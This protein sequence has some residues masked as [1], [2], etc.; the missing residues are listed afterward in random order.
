MMKILIVED[1]ENSR[2]LLEDVLVAGEYEVDSAVNGLEALRKTREAPADLIISDILMPEMDGFDLCRQLK[3]DPQLK[4]IPFIFYT[5][6]YTD[7]RDEKFAMSLGATRFVIKPEDPIRLLEIIKEVFTEQ[8]VGLNDT[9]PY[10]EDDNNEFEVKHSEVLSKKL[11]K[12]IHEIEGQKEQLK[13]IT[14][15]IPALISEIDEFGCYQYSN[16]AHEKW[17]GVSGDQIIGKQIKDVAGAALYE[18]VQP[19]IQKALNGEE[20][21]FEGYVTVANADKRYILA[22]YIPYKNDKMKSYHCFSFINDL[23]PQKQ[24]E[25]EKQKLL[26]QL[27]QSQKQDAIGHLAG[28]IAHDFNNILSIIL[29]YSELMTV[30]EYDN[31]S[32]SIEAYNH[33]IRTAGLRGQD[34]I[35]QIM[36]FSRKSDEQVGF[37]V[38]IK[39]LIKEVIKLVQETF[40]ATVVIDTD[41]A[42]SISSVAIELSQ[43]HQIMVNL[44]VNARDAI[45]LHG[46]ILVTLKQEKVKS[47]V[48]SSCKQPFEGNYVV[49]TISDD[50][51]GIG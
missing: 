37:S 32:G 48:C 35:R 28:G 16:K 43:L 41:L 3:L 26:L 8:Q 12:K 15:A 47:V 36:K 40:P 39:P 33:Q 42:E 5:A 13:F 46:R 45:N 2:I 38:D 22:R 19:Y 29:G 50:G 34:L 9:K 7:E 17:F 21:V 20:A 14:D 10:S 51:T 24:V 27:R 11:D 6:T 25:D 1:T 31:K 44:L 30:A 4:S 18:L 49:L 23:T